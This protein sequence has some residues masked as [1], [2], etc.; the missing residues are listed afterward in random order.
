MCAR[1]GIGLDKGAQQGLYPSRTLIA[2]EQENDV[3]GEDV[4][5]FGDDVA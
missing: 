1:Y 2:A 3:G 4:G 5:A